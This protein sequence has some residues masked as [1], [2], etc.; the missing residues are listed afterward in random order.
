MDM[1]QIDNVMEKYDFRCFI[2]GSNRFIAEKGTTIREAVCEICGSS[3][4]NSDVALAILKVLGFYE[5]YTL[6]EITNYLKH[7]S[8]Y[9]VQSSGTIHDVLSLLP[10]YVCSE[11]FDDVKPGKIHP[12]GIRCEDLQNLHFPD[13]SFDLIITQDVLE[14]VADPEKAF[15]ELY[16]VLKPNG[17]HIFTVPIHEGRNTTKRAWVGDG[18][19]IHLL[20]PV[21]HFDNL[22]PEGGLVFT[23]WGDDLIEYLNSFGFTTQIIVQSQFYTQDKIPYI[24]DGGTYMEYINHKSSKSD[25]LRFFLYNSLVFSTRKEQCP[26]D[27]SI[28]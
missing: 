16:R 6:R 1:D 7:L 24:S 27:H 3:K 25:I 17:H 21:H 2:C 12:S 28:K 18:G 20:P 10:N 13:N 11:Y 15:K 9:E 5:E 22:R 19:V 14:H 4:R 8:I 23:D 26:G